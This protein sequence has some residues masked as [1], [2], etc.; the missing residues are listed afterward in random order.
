MKD[1]QMEFIH[2]IKQARSPLE[3]FPG[4]RS[5]IGILLSQPHECTH[6]KIYAILWRE[7]VLLTVRI[8]VTRH[9]Q[10]LGT[11]KYSYVLY[12]IENEFNIMSLVT[13]T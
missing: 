5:H 11:N 3:A 4:P 6:Y 2:T 13:T 12:K 1:S 10:L 8:C 9:C 7:T